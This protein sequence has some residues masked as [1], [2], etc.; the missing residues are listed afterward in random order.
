MK[1]KDADCWIELYLR[2]RI[3]C[4]AI[5]AVRKLANGVRDTRF[6]RIFILTFFF[7]YTSIA[8]SYIFEY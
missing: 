7:F 4:V 3:T 1:E 2:L 6:Y 5:R 8:N